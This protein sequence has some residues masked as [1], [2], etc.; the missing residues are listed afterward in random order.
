MT[1]DYEPWIEYNHLW[2]TES[3]YLSWIRGGIRRY[4]WSKSPVKLEFEKESKIKIKNNNPRSMKAHPYVA[5]Y[6]CTICEGLFKANECECDHKTGEHPLRSIK[7]V[8][9][10]VQGIVMIRKEDLAMVCKPCHKAKTYAE[11]EGMSIDEARCV[12]LAIA[13]EK[14]GGV[15]VVDFIKKSGIVPAKNAKLRREQLIEIYKGEHK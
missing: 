14:E 8:Q 3:A 1:D 15:Q 6:K 11:R 13:K 9:S 4:L 10:F 12:K 2:K 7:D 5:G